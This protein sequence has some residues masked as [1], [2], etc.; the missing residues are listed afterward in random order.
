VIVVSDTTPLNYLVLIGIVDVLPKLFDEIWIPPSVVHEL[1]HLKTPAVVRHWASQT[2]LWLKIRAPISRLPSTLK[3]GDGESDAIS[4]AKE[5]RVIDI[6]M[7]ER[8]G[9]VV[10]KSEGLTPLPTLAVLEFAA[11]RQLLPLG[12]TIDKLNF[13]NFRAPAGLIQA[14]LERDAA[15]KLAGN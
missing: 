1:S 8:Q 15:R 14:A 10:A 12:P 2:P 3:L 13:T 6:L 9:R 5:L 11:I 7:D 4:L